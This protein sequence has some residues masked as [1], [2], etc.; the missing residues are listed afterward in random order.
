MSETPSA[1]D[2][3]TQNAG[4]SAI[5]EEVGA[6]DDVTPPNE[7]S[8][9]PSPLQS[10]NATNDDATS[11]PALPAV[12]SCACIK[13]RCLKLY[14][15]CFSRGQR[16]AESCECNDCRNNDEHGEERIEAIKMALERKPNAFNDEIKRQVGWDPE[17]PRIATSSGSKRGRPRGS[18]KKNKAG[19]VDLDNVTPNK[20]RRGRPRKDASLDNLPT[21]NATQPPPEAIPFTTETYPQLAID[22][23]ADYSHLATSFTRPL[24]LPTDSS[25]SLPLQI[26]YSHHQAAKHERK[27]AQTKK[28]AVLEEYKKIREKYLEKKLELSLADDEVQRCNRLTGAWTR[29][30]FDLELEEPCAWNE[31]LKRL[32]KFKEENAGRLPPKT[33]GRASEG[34]ERELALWIEKIRG[35]KV[36]Q[37]EEDVNDGVSD[38]VKDEPTEAPDA[39]APTAP[40]STEATSETAPSTVKPKKPNVD[41]A[42]YPHR[43]ESLEQLGVHFRSKSS[44]R[45]EIMFQ[46]L[47]D[48]KEEHG[49]LRFPSD[50]QCAASRDEEFIALQKW[51]KSQVL[52]FRY[53]KKKTDPAIVK[54]FLDI[55]FSFEKWY[56]KP[57]KKKK[58]DSK[59]DEIA[60]NMAEGVEPGDD[61]DNEE[62][63]EE[64]EED[65]D[66]GEEE[67]EY[68]Q[69]MDDG[70]D[71]DQEME[72]GEYEEQ[73]MEDGDDEEQKMEDGDDEEQKFEG[74]DDEELKFDGGGHEEQKIGDSDHEEQHMENIQIDIDL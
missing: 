10:V 45:F 69:E 39:P 57:G 24:F 6:K 22:D 71:E 31:N 14:C 15:E 40:E 16:C 46:K 30:V 18:V 12:A 62:R 25:T 50:E 11:V 41:L 4:E 34:E 35:Q 68:E 5:P 52:N 17:Q 47:L 8:G 9:D 74:G 67:E 66:N 58:M 60:K 64:E 13:T 43:I 26:A 61:D 48:Y 73:K 63:E 32:K 54:R 23:S 72:D 37:D 56:A 7:A 59:F 33:P 38:D 21:I 65:G 70:E 29:K 3:V 27:L 2:P 42:D 36:Q 53:S 28:N 1:A 44:N 49:T 55:G 20:R 19:D 51:V